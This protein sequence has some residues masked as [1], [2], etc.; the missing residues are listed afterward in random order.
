MNFAHHL[1]IIRGGGDLATGVIY[2]LRQAGFP[3]VVL[4]LAQPLV[5]RRRV[6]VAAAVRE[7]E[8][9]IE[10]MTA[11][12]AA[13]VAEAV[14]QAYAGLVPVLVSPELP[15]LP[16]PP[17][18]LIDARMAKRNIDTH[19]D[20]AALV[21]ALGPGFDAGRD[22]HAVIETMRGHRLGRVIWRGAALPNTG[23]P[24]I[25]GGRGA[26]RVIRAPVGGTAE[27][28]V[29]IGQRVRAGQ[30]LGSVADHPMLA[31][32]DGVVRGLI[33]PGTVVSA[34]LKIG[35]VDAREEVDACFT[36]SDKALSI[37]GGVLEAILTAHQRGQLPPTASRLSLPTA[38]G[39]GPA[40]EIV[41]FTGAGGKTS[42]LFALGAALPAGVVMGAT[43]HLAQSEL[44]QSPAVCRLGELAQLDLAL[45]RFG[46]CLLVGEDE[47]EKVAGM[48]PDLPARLLHRPHVRHVLVEA[49]G[50]RRRP[51][52]A[53]AAHEPAI[54]AQTTLVVPVVGIS[55][56]GQP[57]AAA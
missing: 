48:P 11:R 39:I 43:T 30:P 28:L 5:V 29:E 9:T 47:G 38:L 41:A 53:P 6:S 12:R 49:D 8:V 22:C 52:K 32:F 44:A 51:C 13:S 56:I 46:R 42:L 2:R 4:E 57:V 17:S 3:V 35:D 33:A 36:I 24:G 31:P 20:Q 37:G 34:G 21:I 26:E 45:R 1:T 23:T 10:G 16:H 54:P 25:I 19:L 15:D 14:A 50:S 55:A 18:I 27:W 7:G 40:A